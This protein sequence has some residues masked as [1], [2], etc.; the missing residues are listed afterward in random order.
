MGVDPKALYIDMGP[1]VGKPPNMML[2]VTTVG[3]VTHIEVSVSGSGA[4]LDSTFI[5]M[6]GNHVVYNNST[7]SF[8][9]GRVIV[10]QNRGGGGA[11]SK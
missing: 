1:A 11:T 3:K 7:C 6:V 8:N 2:F 4:L 5:S 9:L 10:C